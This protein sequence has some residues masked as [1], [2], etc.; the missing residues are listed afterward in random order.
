MARCSA[1]TGIIYLKRRNKTG[2]HAK[3]AERSAA[4][5]R[6]KAI[7]GEKSNT[8]W[9]FVGHEG[10]GSGVEQQDIADRLQPGSE[11]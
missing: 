4:L 11:S 2:R 3:P 1:L 6:E 9:Y 7:V 8:R 10:D 5:R